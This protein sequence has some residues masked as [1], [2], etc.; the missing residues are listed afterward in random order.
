MSISY[1]FDSVMLKYQGNIS[2]NIVFF[3]LMLIWVQFNVSDDVWKASLAARGI[4]TLVLTSF[5][6]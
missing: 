2:I 1:K 4:V 6:M 3:M 5:Y